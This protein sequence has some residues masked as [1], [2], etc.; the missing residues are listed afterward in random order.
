MLKFFYH[1]FFCQISHLV[2]LGKSK[3]LTFEDLLEVPADIS[4]NRDE[5]KPLL[6]LSSNKNFLKSILVEQK[7]YLK[8]AWSF[9]FLGILASLS[10][11]LLINRFIDSLALLEKNQTTLYSCLPIAVGI[12]L[13][14]IIMGIGYQHNFYGVLRAN[15]RITAR[16]NQ[17]IFEKSLRLSQETRQNINV[18]DVVN[19]MSS[20]TE[21]ISDVPMFLQDE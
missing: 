10:T 14:S 18:G 3:V 21:V 13:I 2:K 5:I 9:Y 1:F 17:L 7:F 19:H 12:G 8:R 15:V 11:P 16:L 4:I 6:D 20:D